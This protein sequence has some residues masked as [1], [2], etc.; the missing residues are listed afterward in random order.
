[1]YKKRSDSFP[2]LLLSVPLCSSHSTSFGP[3]VYRFNIA[4]STVFPNIVISK[5][6]IKVHKRYTFYN[7]AMIRYFVSKLERSSEM[8]IH[9]IELLIPVKC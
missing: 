1:M 6:E 3:Y 8:E 4:R 9:N 7:N 2:P 5:L